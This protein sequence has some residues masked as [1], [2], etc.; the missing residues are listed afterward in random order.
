MNQ[1]N[2]VNDW[3]LFFSQEYW[4]EK[5]ENLMIDAL[6]QS[7]IKVII[8]LYYFALNY[9][10]PIMLFQTYRLDSKKLVFRI[11]LQLEV[12]HENA[13]KIWQLFF[14]KVEQVSLR[15]I[16]III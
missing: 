12:H 7:N 10:R 9:S 5:G 15:Q 6:N 1:I 3:C 16:P 4:A 2:A 13:S 8:P 14:V 11:R